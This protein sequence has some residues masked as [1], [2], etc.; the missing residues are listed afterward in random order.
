MLEGEQTNTRLL[1]SR[2]SS[3]RF[4]KL[5]EMFFALFVFWFYTRLLEVSLFQH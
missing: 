5:S 1:Q 2:L 3:L 4:S